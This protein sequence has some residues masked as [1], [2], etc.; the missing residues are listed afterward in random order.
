MIWRLD[1]QKSE[2]FIIIFLFLGAK[3]I[4]YFETTKK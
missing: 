2:L 4:I 1:A 3:I